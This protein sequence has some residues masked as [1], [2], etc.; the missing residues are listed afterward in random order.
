MTT[1]AVLPKKKFRWD[2]AWLLTRK[3]LGT[4]IALL[5]LIASLVFNIVQLSVNEKQDE[6]LKQTYR[7]AGS[8]RSGELLDDIRAQVV[9]EEGR[10]GQQLRVVAD[11]AGYG[12]FS[13][14]KKF[15]EY[16]DALRKRAANQAGTVRAI[17]L[18][19]ERR[20]E[21]LRIQFR[22]FDA[23]KITDPARKKL[24]AFM[25]SEYGRA[26]LRQL[27]LEDRALH[28]EDLTLDEWVRVVLTA[29]NLIVADLRKW[30][31]EVLF[32]PHLLTVHL[33]SGHR[34]QAIMAIVDFEGAVEETGFIATGEISDNIRSIFDI[35]EKGASPN[36]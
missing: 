22:N 2:F 13:H 9:P 34:D 11:L 30:G 12:A 29:D 10:D 33:W 4:L 25:V 19:D 16:L 6:R 32:Y 26:A 21:V 28:A 14:P 31:V 5:G 1:A 7:R 35:I 23:Y 15:Q 18:N 8:F 24:E 3:G 36:S 17:F 20:E 27:G